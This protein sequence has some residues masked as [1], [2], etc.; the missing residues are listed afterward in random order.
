M[1]KLKTDKHGNAALDDNGNAT[2]VFA[3]GDTLP[4]SVRVGTTIEYYHDGDVD[5]ILGAEGWWYFADWDDSAGSYCVAEMKDGETWEIDGEVLTR[6]G[7]VY[8]VEPE[9]SV[10]TRHGDELAVWTPYDCKGHKLAA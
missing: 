8:T 7:N 1:A 2:I 3:N 5:Q 9:G 4:V 10:W 6:R